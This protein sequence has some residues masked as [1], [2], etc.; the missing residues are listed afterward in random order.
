MSVDWQDLR[1][2]ALA[3]LTGCA[4]FYLGSRWTGQMAQP[5]YMGEQP[6]WIGQVK[7]V[8]LVVLAV[9]VLAGLQLWYQEHRV[10]EQ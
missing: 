7:T 8:Q 6:E 1:V 10:S 5:T 9:L 4:G 2:W 3:L